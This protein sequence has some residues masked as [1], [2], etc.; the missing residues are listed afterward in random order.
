MPSQTSIPPRKTDAVTIA[1]AITAACLA[2]FWGIAVTIIGAIG[3][4]NTLTADAVTIPQPVSVD[5]TPGPSGS[6]HILEGT[7]RTADIVVSGVSDA[8]RALLLSSMI[9]DVIMQLAVVFGVIMLCIA[10]GRGRPFMPAMVRTLVF[11]AFALVICGM[12]SSGLLGFANME[13][14]DALGREDFPMMAELDFTSAIVGV[15]LALVATAFKVGE[16][17]QRD[18]EGLI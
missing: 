12:L 3:A 9:L 8:V 17:L 1:S 18:T 11:M 7:Y 6:L 4:V 5:I 16:R 10:L 15:A 14:A 13:V 2:A